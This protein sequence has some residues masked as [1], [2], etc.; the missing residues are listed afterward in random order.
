MHVLR[1]FLRRQHTNL[2]KLFLV[3]LNDVDAAFDA[4]KKTEG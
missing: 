2:D 1:H 4:F 3:F